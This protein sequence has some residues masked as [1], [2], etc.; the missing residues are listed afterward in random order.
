MET[1]FSFLN[2]PIAFIVALGILV[3][4]HELGHYLMARL[5]GMQVDTFALGMGYRLF[6]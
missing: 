3:F 4:V 6:G 5:T 2:A 1:F